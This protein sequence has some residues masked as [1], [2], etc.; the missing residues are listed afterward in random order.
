MMN[1]ENGNSHLEEKAT[2][3]AL[4]D[5]LRRIRFTLTLNRMTLSEFSGGTK[6]IF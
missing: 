6:W 3:A 2:Y 5:D 1:K 4:K